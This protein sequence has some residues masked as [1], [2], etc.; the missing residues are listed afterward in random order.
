[1]EVKGMIH[2]LGH[3]KPLLAPFDTTQGAVS[4]KLRRGN[5][6]MFYRRKAELIPARKNN[7]LVT[8]RGRSDFAERLILPR[9]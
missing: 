3:K 9:R 5:L 4:V 2:K 1:M 6:Y 7:S 8:E